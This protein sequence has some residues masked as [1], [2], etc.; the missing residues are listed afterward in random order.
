[1]HMFVPALPDAARSLAASAGD[2]QMAISIYIIGLAVGQLVYGPMAD[3]LGRRPVLM[4]GL[5]VYIAGGLAVA[6]SSSVDVMLAGRLVQALGGGAGVALGRTILRDTSAGDT[7][8]ARLATLNMLIVLGPVFAPMAGGLV[9]EAWGWRAIFILLSGAGCVTL[10]LAWRLLPETC[11]PSRHFG[12]GKLLDDYRLLLGSPRFT[13]Y[14]LGAGLAIFSVYAFLSAAPFIFVDDL[15]EPLRRVGLYSGLIVVGTG[16]GNALTVRL[17][18]R[19]P[20]RQLLV[21]G[22]ILSFLAASVL[23]GVVLAG[24]LTTPVVLGGMLAFTLGSGLINPVAMSR[25]MSFEPRLAGSAAGLFGFLQLV[26]G[27]ICTSLSALGPH[28]ALSAM[29]VMVGATALAGLCF[30]VAVRDE[31]RSPPPSRA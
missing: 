21:T 11:V 7:A 24:R 27:A 19:L 13:G 8:V 23:L 3:A 18:R 6:T 28:R 17:V 5:C 22:A 2:M 12:A 16:L 25:A 9:T 26:V 20:G 10:L 15:N 4:S 31:Q 14:A 1:M 29:A 30:G